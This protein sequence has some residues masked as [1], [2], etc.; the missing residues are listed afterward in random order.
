MKT[1]TEKL[2]IILM[3]VLPLIFL[4]ETLRFWWWQAIDYE[5]YSSHFGSLII[6]H[7]PPRPILIGKAV[8]LSIVCLIALS[9]I[10]FRE[11]AYEAYRTILIIATVFSVIY[12]IYAGFHFIPI[13]SVY[14]ISDG[15]GGLYKQEMSRNEKWE[16][17]YSPI[18][19]AISITALIVLGTWAWTRKAIRNH[20][21]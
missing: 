8:I 3:G 19:T 13:Q 5:N 17:I 18:V 9:V 20:F 7:Y 12:S 21:R 6:E 15:S 4:F 14:T 16:E 2:F 11:R 10:S 1:N